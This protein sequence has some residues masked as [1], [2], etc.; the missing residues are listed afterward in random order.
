MVSERKHHSIT[1]QQRPHDGCR[2]WPG[3]QTWIHACLS[4]FVVVLAMGRRIGKTMTIPFLVMEEASRSTRFYQACYMAQGHPQ[5]KDMFRLCLAMW[6]GANLVKNSHADEGQDRW[7]ELIP[8]GSNKGFKMWFVSGE[9]LA[10][11]GFHGKGLDRAIL[12]E[13]SLCPREAWTSTLLPMLAADGKALLLGSPFPEG[14]GFDW[15]EQEFLKGVPDGE[16]R[17]RNYISFCAPTECNPFLRVEQIRVLRNTA[18]AHSEEL[19]LYDGRFARDS[20]AVFKNLK[21]VFC[22]NDFDDRG[23]IWRLRLPSGALDKMRLV[24]GLDFGAKKDYS[25]LSIFTLEDHPRQVLLARTQGDMQGQ[26]R[27]YDA[28]LGEFGHPLLYV[29]G[30][31]EMAADMLAQRY[32]EGCRKVTWSSGGPWDKEKSVMRGMDFFEQKAWSMLNVPWQYDEFRLFSRTPR[33]KKNPHSTGFYYDAPSGSHDDSVAATLYAT[34]G[35]PLAPRPKWEIE[36]EVIKPYTVA[37]LDALHES[38]SG[39]G[40][41]LGQTTLRF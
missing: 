41:R 13:A 2:G 11:P 12:D 31:S 18:A 26:L 33:S 32:G 30:R 7:I 27:T 21:D 17:D 39:G 25:V 16:Q 8:F 36:P 14:M 23:G 6:E 5:A 37:W 28:L 4:Y 3:Q 40:S 20:G 19:C 34:Y 22:L 10:H 29:E 1:F 9:P 24:A 38:Q 15:F 35:M